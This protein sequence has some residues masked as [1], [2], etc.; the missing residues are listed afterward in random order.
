MPCFPYIVFPCN[1]IILIFLISNFIV[2]SIKVFLVIYYTLL[3][4]VDGTGL[5]QTIL[6][7][8]MGLRLPPAR[9]ACGYDNISTEAGQ[10]FRDDVRS[11][12]PDSPRNAFAGKE[13]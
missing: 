11:R 6:C 10:V 12:A 9:E 4:G 1:S 5:R 8:E 2:V 7:A 3:Q 13:G